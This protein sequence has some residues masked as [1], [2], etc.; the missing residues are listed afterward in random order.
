MIHLFQTEE[1]IVVGREL[2]YVNDCYES[3][4]VNG[5]EYKLNDNIV[6]NM[7]GLQKEFGR[8]IKIKVINGQVN[9]SIET[10]EEVEF[11]DHYYVYRVSHC[12]EKDKEINYDDLPLIMQVD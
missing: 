7:S 9:F 3:V 5:I 4:K 10:Y 11:D 8:I 6:T 2:K 12:P 1:P